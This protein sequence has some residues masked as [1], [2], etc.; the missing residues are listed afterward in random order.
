MQM[1]FPC[2]ALIRFGVPGQFEF[3]HLGREPGAGRPIDGALHGYPSP[4]AFRLKEWQGREFVSIGVA[5]SG[6]E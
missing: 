3:E 1:G 6:A 5:A 2:K 4:K